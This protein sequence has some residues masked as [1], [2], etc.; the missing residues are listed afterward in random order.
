MEKLR[1]ERDELWA[2]VNTDKYRNIK[3]MESEKSLIEKQKSDIEGSLHSLQ[4]SLD[5][6]QQ[7]KESMSVQIQE[8]EFSNKRLKE[9]EASTEKLLDVLESK[10]RAFEKEVNL[11]E[12]QLGQFRKENEQLK[13][14]C[15]KLKKDVDWL[16][17]SAKNNKIQAERAISDL[18]AYTQIL[19][20]ME[21]KLAEAEVQKESYEAE[22]KDMRN[23]QVAFIQQQQSI[24]MKQAQQQQ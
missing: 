16:A 11:N 24:Q 23:I 10:N 3:A 19:R 8:L 18:E 12:S 22:L 17:N 20:G 1:K 13:A 21:K 15:M 5:K 4:E 2:V 7:E 9:K 6:L 14:D